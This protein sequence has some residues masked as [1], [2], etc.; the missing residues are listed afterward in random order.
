MINEGRVHRIIEEEITKAE[1]SKMVSDKISSELGSK[2]FDS[3]IREI[4]ADVIETLYRTLWSRS[5][6]WKGQVKR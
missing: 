4:V 2:D 3:K 5:S 1:V 6:T